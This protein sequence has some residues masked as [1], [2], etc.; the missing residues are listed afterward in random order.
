MIF[1]K[2]MKVTAMNLPR[3]DRKGLLKKTGKK[4]K[5]NYLHLRVIFSDKKHKL[6]GKR[7][8]MKLLN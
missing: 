5:N 1:P 6:C 7:L 8:A 4:R 3:S 2:E